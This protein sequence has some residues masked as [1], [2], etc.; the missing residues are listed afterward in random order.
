MF[1]AKNENCDGSLTVT[2]I[3]VYFRGKKKSFNAILL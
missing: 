1:L 2:R 3:L